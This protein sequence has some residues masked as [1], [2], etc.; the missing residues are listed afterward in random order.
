[1]SF[2]ETFYNADGD[3]VYFPPTPVGKT[4][5]VFVDIQEFHEVNAYS[6]YIYLQL[7]NCT[8]FFN[9]FL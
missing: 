1:M 6:Y 5:K 7:K 4:S 8:G 3:F 2:D 9:C